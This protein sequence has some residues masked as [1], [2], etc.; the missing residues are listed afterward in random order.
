MEGADAGIQHTFQVTEDQFAQ[1][2]RTLVNFKRYYYVAIAYAYNNYENY[3]PNDPT[4]LDGQKKRYISSRK[5]PTGEIKVLECI[6]HN[7]SPETN[8]LIQSLPY[9]SG[10]QI[11][12]LDGYGN[13]GRI[14]ELTTSSLNTIIGNGYVENPVYDY[15][16][17]PIGVKVVDPLNV[18]G[19][20]FECKFSDYSTSNSNGADTAKWT[21]Y[22]Y[23][24]PNGNILDFVTSDMTI[25]RDN[26]QVIPQWGVSVQI[27][28]S[29]YYDDIAA[30]DDIA[31]AAADIDAAAAAVEVDP[32]PIAAAV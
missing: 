11:T 1:G 23:D 17:G 29:N 27:H 14:L 20:Y 7:P 5:A 19:G 9:G 2:N 13:G 8:G 32:Y 21:I 12:R 30:D 22:R 3:D 26:E 24:A 6:P 25:E 16:K 31:A 15:G 18:V 10:P 4:A 28:Q